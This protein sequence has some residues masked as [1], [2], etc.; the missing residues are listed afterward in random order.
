M[1]MYRPK[2]EPA[3]TE[4]EY[5]LLDRYVDVLRLIARL[6]PGGR[7]NSTKAALN[8]AE[9]LVIE[10]RYLR[11]AFATM[12]ERGETELHTRTLARILRAMEADRH[13]ERTAPLETP[14]TG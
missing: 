6:N 4:A 2:N 7:T 9:L 10:S 3:L 1:V 8:A 13:A 11:D 14:A 12:L 5:D